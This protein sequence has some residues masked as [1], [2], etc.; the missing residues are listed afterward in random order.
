MTARNSRASMYACRGVNSSSCYP[1]PRLSR[2]GRAPDPSRYVLADR[3]KVHTGK[4]R[5]RPVLC[6]EDAVDRQVRVDLIHELHQARR[7]RR[8]R[9][10]PGEPAA[11]PMVKSRHRTAAKAPAAT[12]A[13][14]LSLPLP[15][16]LTNLWIGSPGDSLIRPPV[17]AGASGSR[18]PAR[19]PREPRVGPRNPARA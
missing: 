6:H 12:I 11:G 14:A 16:P 3:R 13:S 19:C 18:P 7:F 4:S 5:I 15:L 10:S 17:R 9:G 1:T 2:R 8:T